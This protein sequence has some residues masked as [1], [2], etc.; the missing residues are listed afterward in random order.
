[1]LNYIKYLIGYFYQVIDRWFNP[2]KYGDEALGAIESYKN[3][4][5][6][7]KDKTAQEVVDS[8][9]IALNIKDMPNVFNPIEAMVA[10]KDE[11]FDN[12]LYHHD[13]EHHQLVIKYDKGTGK[14]YQAR[15]H[16]LRRKMTKDLLIFPKRV[17][18]YDKTHLHNIGFHGSDND[19]R[20]IIGWDSRQNQQDMRLFEDEVIKINKKEP[21]Y[22][23]VSIEL[24]SDFTAKW[25]SK[26]Y[27]LDGQLLL[28]REFHDISK[29]SW[30]A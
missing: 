3:P 27:N 9:Q 24:Q 25:Y 1:M 6:R 28:E 26:I 16:L 8:G 2:Y 23:Y 29:F 21:I 5:K 14:R 13:W 10:L 17:K 15:N 19:K 12:G 7:N 20:I 11:P 30:I 18:V 22:W 4:S